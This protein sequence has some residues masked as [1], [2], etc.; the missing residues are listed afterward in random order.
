MRVSSDSARVPMWD[1]IRFALIVLVS[2]GHFATENMN[3]FVTFRKIF[4]F[5]YAFHMPMFIFLSGL[6]HKDKDIPRKA[7]FFFSVFLFIK[8]VYSGLDMIKGQPFRLNLL[9]T[10]GLPW[11]MFFMT[12]AVVITFLLRNAN[13]RVVLGIWLV[14]ALVSGYVEQIDDFLVL[15]R[16]IVYYPYYLLGNMLKDSSKFKAICENR[17]PVLGWGIII[18]WGLICYYLYRY[19]LYVSHLFSGRNPYGGMIG[20]DFVYRIGVYILTLV[21]GWAIIQIAPRRDLGVVTLMG[22]RTINSYFWHRIILWFMA[23]WHLNEVLVAH[24]VM[25]KLLW[26]LLGVA[27]AFISS[28]KPFTFPIDNFKHLLNNI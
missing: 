12:V 16:I 18:V 17:K 25:G 20:P 19:V 24:G 4:L 21:I 28:T 13:K 2:I 1:N 7:T 11:F 15:S 27:V 3:D 26:I 10:D 9:V 6:F 5:I 8:L 23:Y 22:G 14:A